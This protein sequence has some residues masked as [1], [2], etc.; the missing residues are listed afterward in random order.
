M[1]AKIPFN[2]RFFEISRISQHFFVHKTKLPRTIFSLKIWFKRTKLF[3][4]SELRKKNFWRDFLSSCP[5]SRIVQP[6]AEACFWSQIFFFFVKII[7]KII[8]LTNFYTNFTAIPYIFSQIVREYILPI[9][10]EQTASYTM[11]QN[12]WLSAKIF[13]FKNGFLSLFF[14]KFN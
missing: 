4:S 12:H 8:S 10:F 5:K 2:F 9:S 1:C 14:T 13:L 11:V 7:P 6:E 3:L